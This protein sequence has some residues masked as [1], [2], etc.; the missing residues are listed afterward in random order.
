MPYG[1]W[2][3]GI[4]VPQMSLWLRWTKCYYYLGEFYQLTYLYLLSLDR[5]LLSFL[6]LSRDLDRFLSR[7]LERFLT[8]LSLDLD[9]FLSLDRDLLSLDLDRLSLDLDLL[10][11]SFDLDLLD[12]FDLSLLFDL[13]LLLDFLLYDLKRHRRTSNYLVHE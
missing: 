8:F 13:D 3:I 7:D 12:L 10:C 2:T 4:L 9:R 6:L 11:L 1:C 5:D